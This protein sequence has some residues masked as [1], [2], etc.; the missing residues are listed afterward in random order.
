MPPFCLIC[1]YYTLK[2][3][4]SKYFTV[5]SFIFVIIPNKDL[6]KLF[7]F[8]KISGIINIIMCIMGENLKNLK[9]RTVGIYTLGCKVNQYESQAIAELFEREGFT[10]L[11]YNQVCS[12]YI[13][14]TC[15]VTAESDRKARQFIRRAIS[16]NPSAYIL[17]TGC[18]AQR[19]PQDVGNI[20]GVDYICGSANKT[21]VLQAALD[22]MAKGKKNDSP[23]YAVSSL[24]DAAFEEMNITHFE[25]TRA[26]VKIED[27]C[28]N[29]CAYCAIPSARGHVR[30]KAPGDVIAEVERLVAGGCREIVLTGI[31]TA[32]YGRDLNGVTLSDL[33][34][35][36]DAIEG[37]GRVRLGSL[38]PSLMR[39]DFVEKIAG[40]SS[41]APHFHLSLQS[42]SDRIL[43]AMKRKY[44]SQKM[45]Q[46]IENI[47]KHIP[48]VRL[49]TDVIVGFP[50]ETEED[51]LDTLE[52]AEKIRFLDIHVFTYSKRAGTV[53]ATLPN[54]IPEQVKKERSARLSARQKEIKN[55]LLSELVERGKPVD[56]LFETYENG[57]AMGHTAAFEEFAVE[58]DRRL[59][60]ENYSVLP[61][62]VENG[63]CI[64]LLVK[65]D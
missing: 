13:I 36:I 25:R 46:N 33:L 49:T 58:C 24:R 20:E 17:V 31:E 30:S 11:S 1:L 51:F 28:E 53:A 19:S 7:T 50:G 38:D 45:L 62:R 8:L 12:V 4:K 22:L 65:E 64:G 48:D 32:S 41:L 56:V 15:T 9:N 10:V 39:E 18:F 57:V 44:N 55:E 37:I 42:G 29:R 3:L 59:S 2:S 26:Y 6:Q 61:Q 43:S 40:L 47:K 16:K 54:Q 23:Q 60:G 63:V 52:M 35:K 34:C 27:G 14:N 5:F 21:S